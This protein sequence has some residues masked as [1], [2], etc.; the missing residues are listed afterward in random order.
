MSTPAQAA[1]LIKR[2]QLIEEKLEK[3][4]KRV[5]YEELFKKR[6]IDSGWKDDMKRICMDVIKSKGIENVRVEELTEEL[7]PK[8]KAL[9]P[10]SVKSELLEKIQAFIE[11]DP[12]YKR[13]YDF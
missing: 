9:I 8:G 4:G 7:V 5:E 1:E 10:E 3:T 11:N 13:L 6:L 12:D 2:K